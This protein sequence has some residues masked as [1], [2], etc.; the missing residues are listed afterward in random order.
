MLLTPRN[1]IATH[2]MP[3][4]LTVVPPRHHSNPDHYTPRHAPL[5]AS[6]EAMASLFPSAKPSLKPPMW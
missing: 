5:T 2:F 1:C 3:E 4:G 6:S